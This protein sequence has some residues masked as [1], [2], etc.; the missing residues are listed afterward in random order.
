MKI[1]G[2]KLWVVKIKTQKYKQ[3]KLIV[4]CL[5]Q[6]LNTPLIHNPTYVPKELQ[7]ITGW[8]LPSFIL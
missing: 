2:G 4:V 3:A 6:G 7:A 1:L 5:I 8:A